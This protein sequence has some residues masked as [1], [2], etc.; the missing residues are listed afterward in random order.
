MTKTKKE[1]LYGVTS[2]GKRFQISGFCPYCLRDVKLGAN[3]QCLICGAKVKR[4]ATNEKLIHQFEKLCE[5]HKEIMESWIP[6]TPE[7]EQLFAKIKIGFFTYFVSIRYL[8]EFENLQL[9]D[10]KDTAYDDFLE[11]IKKTCPRIAF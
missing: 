4:K 5:I 7:I 1:E 8:Q 2:K 6:V 9:T 10:N 3:H 11:H